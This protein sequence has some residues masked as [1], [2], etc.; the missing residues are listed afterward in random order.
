MIDRFTKTNAKF[1]P[2]LSAWR[3]VAVLLLVTPIFSVAETYERVIIDPNGQLHIFTKD[4]REILPV[5]EKEQTGVQQ[6]A[7]APDHR[8][9]GKTRFFTGND[10]P[11]WHWQFLSAEK[12]AAFDQETIH[13]GLGVHCELRDVSTGRL[14]AA[15]KPGPGKTRKAGRADDRTGIRKVG[16]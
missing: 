2:T 1:N 11:I 8:A 14:V 9:D 5:K 6:A 13:G 7:I 3:Y 16:A 4:R 12:Q 10:L 15:S